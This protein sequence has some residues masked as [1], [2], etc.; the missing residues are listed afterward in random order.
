MK[1]CDAMIKNQLFKLKIMGS[2]LFI[3]I[4]SSHVVSSK[5]EER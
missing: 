5:K 3:I 2:I 4:V 1:K